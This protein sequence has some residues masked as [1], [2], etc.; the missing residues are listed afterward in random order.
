MGGH[1][2]VERFDGPVPLSRVEAGEHLAAKVAAM[3]AS[4]TR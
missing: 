1:G 3:R 2:G 4:S